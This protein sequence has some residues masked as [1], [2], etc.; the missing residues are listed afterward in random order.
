MKDL[1]N[2]LETALHDNEA[3]I[4]DC[5]AFREGKINDVSRAYYQG[6]IDTL[7]ETRRQLRTINRFITVMK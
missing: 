7:E 1:I 5:Q 3:A 6:K 4:L 2:Y